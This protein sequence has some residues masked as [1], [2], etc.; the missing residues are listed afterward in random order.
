MSDDDVAVAEELRA[1]APREAL[2]RL[3]EAVT[4]AL[5]LMATSRANLEPAELLLEDALTEAR[6]SL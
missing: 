6:K 3:T 5:N 2:L 4:R 1:R